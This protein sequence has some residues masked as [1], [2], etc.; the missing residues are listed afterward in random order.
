MLMQVDTVN[1]LLYDLAHDL[2]L[3]EKAWIISALR[4]HVNQYCR[5]H[6]SGYD[7]ARCNRLIDN[8]IESRK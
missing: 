4:S 6:M 8:W 5:N 3:T 1:S 7:E 2:D